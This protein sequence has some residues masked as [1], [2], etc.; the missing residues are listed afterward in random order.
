MTDLQNNFIPVEHNL[1]IL[2]SL[3]KASKQFLR[4]AAKQAVVWTQQIRLML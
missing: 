3:E 2:G 1:W 4:K